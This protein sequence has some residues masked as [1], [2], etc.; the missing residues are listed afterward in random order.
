MIRAVKIY[1]LGTRS[2]ERQDTAANYDDSHSNGRNSFT[3]G[4]PHVCVHL[5]NVEEFKSFHFETKASIHHKEHQVCYFRQV[6]HRIHIIRAFEE[7][8]AALLAGHDGD[9]T[10]RMG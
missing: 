3:Y 1:G 9:W 5:Q 7:G 6:D 10:L 2:E 8:D 4:V